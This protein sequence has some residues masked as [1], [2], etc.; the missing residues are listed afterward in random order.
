MWDALTGGLTALACRVVELF[1]RS[2]F[3]ILDELSRTEVYTWLQYL[4]WFIPIPTFVGILE[5][6]LSG[7]ALYYAYQIVL[8]WIKV[9]E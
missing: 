6:W 5:M 2:P 9:I 3:V 7:V 8:R 1:P 4:N